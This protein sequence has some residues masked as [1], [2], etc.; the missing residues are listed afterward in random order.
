MT[1]SPLVRRV[2]SALSWSTLL[3]RLPTEIRNTRITVMSTVRL[4]SVR[5]QRMIRTETVSSGSIRQDFAVRNTFWSTCVWHRSSRSLLSVT[6]I[7][8]MTTETGHYVAW[9]QIPDVL[10]A[11]H[12]L[13]NRDMTI[14]VRFI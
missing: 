10:N 9:R 7:A 11:Q 5:L 13:A 2:W 8:G 3:P 4:I 12:S 6:V 14:S 1:L